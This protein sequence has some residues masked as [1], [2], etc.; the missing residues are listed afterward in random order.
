MEILSTATRCGESEIWNLDLLLL[1][2]TCQFDC[3]EIFRGND[4]SKAIDTV[5]AGMW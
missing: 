4:R 3:V 1:P 5:L 2:E